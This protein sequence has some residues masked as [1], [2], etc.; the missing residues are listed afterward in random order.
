MSQLTEKF[1][2]ENFTKS[3]RADDT[4][5]PVVN[6][7]AYTFTQNELLDIIKEAFIAQCPEEVKG[8]IED[9]SVCDIPLKELHFTILLAKKEIY[10]RL[11]T[12]TAPFY[13]IEA[14]GA[15]LRKDYRFEH[16]MSL[17][18]RIEQEYVT[19]NSVRNQNLTVESHDIIIDK[20]HFT[21]RNYNVAN[22]PEIKVEYLDVHEQYVDVA[23]SKFSVFGGLF[24]CYKIFLSDQEIFDEFEN[25]ISEK[26]ECVCQINDIHRNKTRLK[27][28]VAGK[29]YHLMIQSLD[30][31]S[32][33]GIVEVE[34]DTPSIVF[35][36]G[37]A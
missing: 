9:V 2:L 6:D 7:P 35:T 34:F 13:P 37:Q 15:S 10:Y 17:V 20:Y 30:R 4:H 33:S 29:H 22:S 8:N 3:I 5:L 18:R 19:L 11:A 23:W 24:F 32:L 14:E 1:V 36:G 27:G 21:K 31:N 28:L 25:S 26:A 12:S 16:Y